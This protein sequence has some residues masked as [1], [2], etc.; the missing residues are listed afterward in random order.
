VPIEENIRLRIRQNFIELMD[1]QLADAIMESMPPI[2]WTDLATKDDIARLEL[3]FDS[4]D[5][6]FDSVDSR[7]ETIATR[8]DS[9]DSRFETIATRFDSVDSRFETMATRFDSV[10]SQFETMATRFDSVDSRFETMAKRFESLGTELHSELSAVEGRLALQFMETTRMVIFA[11]MM[12]MTAV[13]GIA[14]AVIT[15]T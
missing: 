10:D 5:S 8:F 7:F 2:P 13:L 11:V 14:V 15:T 4:V 9:V 3:R 6:R 1:E 12:L